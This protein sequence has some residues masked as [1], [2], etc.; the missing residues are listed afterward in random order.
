MSASEASSR[1]ATLSSP[2]RMFSVMM[3]MSRSRWPLLSASCHSAVS[4]STNQAR[5]SWPSRM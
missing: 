5:M 4:A 3:S 1:A 2:P